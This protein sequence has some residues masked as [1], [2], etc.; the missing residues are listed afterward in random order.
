[1][2]DGTGTNIQQKLS[3]NAGNTKRLLAQNQIHEIHRA[4]QL[5]ARRQDPGASTE[6]ADL[7]VGIVTS[8]EQ[9]SEAVMAK[10]HA[11]LAVDG[12]GPAKESERL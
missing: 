5:F 8:V 4:E 6:C 11:M 9:P 1:M 12:V 2:A 3:R 7:C 10:A